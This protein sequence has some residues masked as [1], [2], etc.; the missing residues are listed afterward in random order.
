LRLGA[1]N[2]DEHHARAFPARLLPAVCQHVLGAH[3]AVRDGI[4]DHPHGAR[5]APTASAAADSPGRSHQRMTN[6]E[7]NETDQHCEC[8]DC[9]DFFV[10][11]VGQQQFFNERGLVAPKRCPACRAAKRQRG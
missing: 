7:R 8:I 5:A 11:T 4:H 9:G 6:N 1:F 3:P 2:D 10:F